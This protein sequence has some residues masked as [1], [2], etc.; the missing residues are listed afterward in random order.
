MSAGTLFRLFAGLLVVL[1]QAMAAGPAGATASDWSR[2]DQTEVRLIAG[3]T[4]TG[5]AGTIPLGLEFRLQPGWKVYWRFPGAGGLPPQLDWSQSRNVAEARIAWPAPKRFDFQGIESFGYGDHVVYPIQLRLERPGEAVGLVAGLEYLTCREICIPYQATLSLDLP[6]GPASSA[7]DAAVLAEWVDKVPGDGAAH[8]LAIA[9]A[10]IETGADGPH[11]VATVRADPPLA[12]PDLFVETD[13]PIDVRAPRMTAVDGGVRLAARIEGDPAAIARLAGSAVTLTL[14]DGARAAEARAIVTTAAPAGPPPASIEVWIAI[15][16]TALLGGLILN[17]MPCVLPVLSLKLL[18][19]VE[20]GGRERREVRAGF[21]AAAAGILVSFLVLAA[22][23]IALQSAG[24]AVGWG[25][26]FQEPW[27]LAAMAAVVTLFAANLWGWFDIPLPGFAGVAPG[28]DR[29]GPLGHFL[30]GA[31]AAL[32]ATPCSAPFVGTAIGFALS[33]GPVEILAIFAALGLGLALP[34]VA[35]AAFP[36]LAARLPRPGRW[37]V[38][39]RRV[40][41]L[42]LVATA[43]WLL[44]VLAAQTGTLVAVGLGAL[45]ALAALLIGPLARTPVAVRSSLA[46]ATLVVFAIAIAPRLETPAPA[47]PAAAA[48]SWQP[49]DRDRIAALVAEGKTV[50]VDVTADWC[51]TCQVNKKLVLSRGAVAERLGGDGIVAMRADWTRPDA[52]IAAYLAS[53]GRYGIPFNAVYGPKS[54]GGT[55]LPEL[56]TESAVIEALDRAGAPVQAAGG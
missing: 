36:G 16:A 54:P 48:G 45:L 12:A 17:L 18:G 31:F 6:A 40:L 42:V 29:R 22:V 55:A 2:T 50:F 53:F 19:V 24:L 4:A 39:V 28:A 7:P 34:Y 56:L 20:A 25:I 27:F 15:L 41:A 11:L 37:M 32:L 8:G 44:F 38:A 35:V 14:V 9:A 43:V 46:A 13:L 47:R 23:A 52:A 5:T 10:T 49:F 1:I 51:I 30:T 26:Q 3:T 33:R 21:V